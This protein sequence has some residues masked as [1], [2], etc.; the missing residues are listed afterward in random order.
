MDDKIFIAIVAALVNLLL[1]VLVPCALKN[2]EASYLTGVKKMFNQNREMLVTSSVL[3]GV[4]VYLSLV[5]A[6]T[7]RAEMPEPL[8]NLMSLGR[9]R[10]P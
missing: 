6:P 5:A 1:S 10:L 7:V 2:Q 8:L 4:I 9:P 3:V